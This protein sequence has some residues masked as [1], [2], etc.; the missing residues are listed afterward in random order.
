MAASYTELKEL[1]EL[2]GSLNLAISEIHRLKRPPSLSESHAWTPDNVER[3][4]TLLTPLT[5]VVD[6]SFPV[7]KPPCVSQHVLL[8]SFLFHI[9]L[10][11]LFETLFFFFYVSTLENAGILKT[12]GGFTQT[13]VDEC[14]AM[15]PDGKRLVEWMLTPY[16]NTTEERGAAAY[17]SR[18]AYNH[19]L[20]LLSW[21]YAIGLVVL[22][23]A[24]AGTGFYRRLEIPW[25]RLLLENCGLVFMLGAFEVLFFTT[26]VYPYLPITGQEIA[27][28]TVAQV[29]AACQNVS[30]M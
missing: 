29:K 15:G 10:I 27:A 18:S 28:N 22:F 9:V 30:S 8:I 5:I 13:L 4:A 26:I 20:L 12:V 16:V 7:Q 24:A 17:E 19:G 6:D 11:S 23:A 1:P 21:Y 3:A 25:R 14:E 2:R